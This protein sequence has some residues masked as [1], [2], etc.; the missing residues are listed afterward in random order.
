MNERVL[1]SSAFLAV[2][3]Q[4]TG[5]EI[6]EPMLVGAKMSSVNVAEVFGK[7]AEKDK[8]TS[9]AV[10]AFQKSGVEVVPFDFDQA[11][12][13]GELRLTTKHLWL[14]LGDRCCLALAILRNA[15]AVTADRDWKDLSFCPVEVI[16]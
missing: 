10:E 16:R 3:Y 2:I 8:L 13:A 12:K 5:S 6:V 15:M 7:L 14:S 1:D 9:S 11:Q 4:E